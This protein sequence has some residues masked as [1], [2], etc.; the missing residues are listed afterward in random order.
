MK[1]DH[2]AG[3]VSPVVPDRIEHHDSIAVALCDEAVFEPQTRQAELDHGI[4]LAVAR[5]PA[6]ARD[7]IERSHSVGLL[8]EFCGGLA[9]RRDVADGHDPSR[10]GAGVGRHGTAMDLDQMFHAVAAVDH[11]VHLNRVG[12]L[13]R[14]R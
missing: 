5:H 7:R 4:D 10:C 2:F 9:F 3:L 1:R 6:F 14:V 12:A 11:E 8:G 13:R